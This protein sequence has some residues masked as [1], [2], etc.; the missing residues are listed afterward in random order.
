MKKET[1][2]FVPEFVVKNIAKKIISKDERYMNF[3]KN[4]SPEE[5][6]LFE[7]IVSKAYF[8]GNMF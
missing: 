4:L 1:Q 3:L 2:L 8:M 5:I 6:E 7:E